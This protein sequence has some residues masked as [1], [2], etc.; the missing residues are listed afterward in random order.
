MNRRLNRVWILV[1]AA[2]LAAVPGG[3]R[4]LDRAL[5]D[6]Y[7]AR[8]VAEDGRVID[9]GNRNMS[10][11]EGQGYGLILAVA[12]DDRPAFER[13]R[14]WTRD[15]LQVRG[16]DRLLAWAWGRRPNGEW[17]VVDYNNATDG[18]LLAAYGLLLAFERWNEPAWRTEALELAADIKKHLV[19]EAGG[20]PVLLP[21]YYGFERDGALVVNPAYYVYPALEALARHDP[22]PVWKE[23]LRGGLDLL[24]RARR[25]PWNLP[26]DWILARPDGLEVFRERSSR[27]G[28]EAVRVPLYLAWAGRREALQP[29]SAVLDWFERTGVLPLWVDVV[30]PAVSLT[31]APG[32]FYAVWAAAAERLGR[33]ATAERLWSRAREQLAREKDDY[34]SATLHLLSLRALEA[35]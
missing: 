35:R 10:H 32:G 25:P 1:A 8:F 27:F 28:Y 23:I 11:S 26:P 20:G 5:W 22:D 4:A 30:D 24:D 34:Y 12:A 21:G 31:E 7:K 16:G 17:G 19:A 15:N 18:D 2:F 29:W 3:A 9:R 13:I 33:P 14:Q 6:A